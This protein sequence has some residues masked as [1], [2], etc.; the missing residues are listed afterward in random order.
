MFVLICQSFVHNIVAQ[1]FSLVYFTP[2]S[3]FNELRFW[4]GLTFL[5]SQIGF[6]KFS[7]FHFPPLILSSHIPLLSTAQGEINVSNS[8]IIYHCS[9]PAFLDFLMFL[10]FFC[11][12][13]ILSLVSLHHDLRFFIFWWSAP[14][15]TKINFLDNQIVQ[16]QKIFYD[17][18][19][20]AGLVW[21][22]ISNWNI[23]LMERDGNINKNYL[24][25]IS[26]T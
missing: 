16:S 12:L 14:T 11:R 20:P 3:A 7:N 4:Y 24:A 23:S 19:S 10:F 26:K 2:Q 21:Y 25:T 22:L 13:G 6:C 1:V 18:G 5:M 17:E 9:Q 8:I 15:P